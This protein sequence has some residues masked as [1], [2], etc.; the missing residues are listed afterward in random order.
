MF[1]SPGP[2]AFHLG[3]FDIRWY[4][5]I[6]AFA[7]LSGVFIS[8]KTARL[9]NEDPENISSL[10]I[11]LL[12]SAIIGARLYYVIFNLDYFANNISEIF[13]TWHGGLSIHGALIGGFLSG[14]VYCLIKKLSILKYADIITYGLVIGQAIGRWGNFF[15]SEAYGT[16]TDLPWKIYIPYEYRPELFKTYDYFH[17]AFLYEFLWNIVVFLVLF[18][19]IKPHMTK[20]NGCIFFSYLI[21]YSTGRFLIEQIRIDNIYTIYGLPLAQFVSILLFFTGC[22]GIYFV[23]VFN[24]HSGQ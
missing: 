23:K 6:I 4:G 8:K 17:P 2:V 5:L 16:P 10:S 20:N 21:L 7:F 19:V 15:N 9:Y 13:K 1:T 22:I 12:I 14:T 24:K 11:V 3:P 18:F